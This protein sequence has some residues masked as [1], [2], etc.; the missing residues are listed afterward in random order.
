MSSRI[1]PP[2]GNVLRI[3]P[4]SEDVDKSKS[5]ACLVARIQD[6]SESAMGEL[7]ELVLACA[8]PYLRW[9]LGS[10]NVQADM[11]DR[12]H[13]TYLA[14]VARE[15]SPSAYNARSVSNLDQRASK[16]P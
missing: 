5:M 16:G 2:P 6:G 15:D 7:Y 3:Y 9:R 8:G 10:P 11:D 13:D 14:A 4:G 12:L 1:A